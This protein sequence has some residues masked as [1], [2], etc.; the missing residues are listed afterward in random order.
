MNITF[1]GAIAP[2]KPLTDSECIA[3]LL[4]L[5]GITEPDA[6][7][8][9]KSPLDISIL[10][11][12]FK[13]QMK[14]TIALLKNIYAKKQRVVVYT[15]YDAD[16][17]TGGAIV[18]ETLHLLGFDVMPY[19]PHRQLEGYGFSLIGIDNVKK[20]FDP[21]LI[22]SVDHGIT[23]VHQI[24]Y[25]KALGIPV[26]VTDHHQRQDQI[27]EAAEAIFHIPLLSGSGVGYF[28]AK[29]IFES[30]REMSTKNSKK[31]EAYFQTDYL[32]LASI[33]TIADLVPLVGS[34]RSVVKYGLEAFPQVKRAGIRQLCR[35]AKIADR[36]I[37]P[38][39]I[40]FVIAPRINAVGRLEHAL[41]A[42]RL[43]CTTSDSKASELA[44]RV[45]QLNTDRQELVKTSV[46]EANTMVEQ[47]KKEGELPH[48]LILH[49]ENWHEGV[50]GLIASNIL[51]SYYR[52]VI[53]MAQGDGQ[54][55]GSARSISALHITHF[56]EELKE[57]F[58]N[59]GGHAGAAG[60]TMSLDKLEGFKRAAIAKAGK[61]LK[62]ADLVRKMEVDL[63]IPVSYATLS[64][65]RQIEHLSPFG[66]GNPSPS[67]VSRVELM[68][69]SIFGK[70]KTHLKLL[71]KDIAQSSFPLEMIAFGKADL[72][73][74]LSRGQ[75]LQIAYQLDINRW[76][77]KESLRGKVLDI[78]LL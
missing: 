75:Q 36:S 52:P 28:F 46:A 42:L 38:Y 1:K 44:G 21:A 58:L 25:A 6:F 24:A 63:S 48:I 33:G 55:K 29:E 20:E 37:T 40:G 26:I 10:D 34:S 19:V 71:V 59:F 14:R 72:F 45:G 5:R 39:E 78:E 18:W 74:S 31:L 56:F 12:G 27:P 4:K 51:E 9:P 23:A 16:G 35:E 64:L 50:I 77:G 68:S 73:S 66:I 32:S 53:V 3:L 47:M 67:F 65:A 8:H 69:A 76:N 49:A 54:L 22:I 7:I 41:D 17:I 30:L 70:T 13:A 57:Y 2:D 60:F 61:Q 15:D 43:L 62:A 11:F